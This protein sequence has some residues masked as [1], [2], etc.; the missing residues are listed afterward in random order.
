M[1]GKTD[2][3][4]LYA[5]EL[6]DQ[7]EGSSATVGHHTNPYHHSSNLVP[8]EIEE[9]GIEMPGNMCRFCLDEVVHYID[10]PETLKMRRDREKRDAVIMALLE[11]E[12][13]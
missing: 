10:F 1:S 3:L 12:E 11:N 4:R 5:P 7:I 6:I 2:S 8:E 9:T 13:P